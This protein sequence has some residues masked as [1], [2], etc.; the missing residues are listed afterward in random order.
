MA[1]LAESMISQ[2]FTTAAKDLQGFARICKDLH[3]FY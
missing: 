3:G 1:L 2:H